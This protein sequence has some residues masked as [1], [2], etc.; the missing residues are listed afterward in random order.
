MSRLGLELKRRYK[1]TFLDNRRGSIDG[2]VKAFSSNY[3]RCIDSLNLTLRGLLD[4]ADSSQRGYF[5]LAKSLLTSE[6][7]S[8]FHNTYS[9]E[10]WKKLP[11]DVNSIFMSWSDLQGKC[12]KGYSYVGTKDLLLDE[13]IKVL[14]GIVQFEAL[15]RQHFNTSLNLSILA[16][17]SNLKNELEIERTSST[18]Y[19]LDSIS[20]WI[21]EPVENGDNLPIRMTDIGE[22]T[23][24]IFHNN[25]FQGKAKILQVGSLL[26]SVVRAQRDAITLSKTTIRTSSYERQLGTI[27]LYNTHDSTIQVLLTELGIIDLGASGRTFEQRFAA[28]LG[29]SRITQF[30]NGLRLPDYG[31]TLLVE[32]HVIQYG[33]Q[34]DKQFPVVRM[35]LYNEPDVKLDGPF[36]WHSIK[37]GS[38][39]RDKLKQNGFLK[40]EL[41]LYYP[42]NARHFVDFELDCPQQIFE[43]A[44]D[45]YIFAQNQEET[46]CKSLNYSR[47]NNI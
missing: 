29:R 20:A 30:Y 41:D 46:F 9:L 7:T 8:S 22:Q 43:L 36:E 38:I 6:G 12:I 31:C 2:H 47:I 33:K 16:I 44:Y 35:F 32:L 27:N 5:D 39:C 24:L 1:S 18:I 14:P 34:M 45:K 19:Y 10:D 13:D 15:I 23:A 37:I 25:Q 28:S 3:E 40:S 26:S 4:A 17:N 21:D 42:E 11:I